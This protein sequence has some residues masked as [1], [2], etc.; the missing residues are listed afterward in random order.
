MSRNI[1]FREFESIKSFSNANI[2]SILRA[3]INESANAALVSTFDDGAILFDV[4]EE[5][6]YASKFHFDKENL[7]VILEGFEELSLKKRWNIF[8]ASNSLD[9]D[10]LEKTILLE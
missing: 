6:F 5:K 9:L 8:S 7:E 2:E 3:Y 4:N 10:V 1:T